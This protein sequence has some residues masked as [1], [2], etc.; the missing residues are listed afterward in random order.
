MGIAIAVRTTQGLVTEAT[1]GVTGAAD[2]AFAGEG[3]ADFLIGK[4]LS[5]ETIDYAAK[6]LSQGTACLSDR[7]APADYRANLLEVEM[8]RALLALS[9]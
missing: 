1:L 4:A 6:L 8:R 3:A 5:R 7:Y 9:P 2:H